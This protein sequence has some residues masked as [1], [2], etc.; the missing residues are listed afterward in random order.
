MTT[1]AGLKTRVAR[2]LRDPSMLTFLD[3]DLGDYV[4]R[5]IVEV[6][7]YAPQQFVEDIALNA[8]QN[9]Y[10]VRGGTGNLLANPSFEGGDATIVQASSPVSVTVGNASNLLSGWLLT[11][12]TLVRFTQSALAKAGIYIGEMTVNAAQAS[13]RLYQD[14]PVNPG[15]TYSFSGWHWKG[16]AGGIANRI[17]VNS[18]DSGSTVIAFNVISHDTTAAVP[19][20]ASGTYTTPA[21]GTVVYLRVELLCN[22]TPSAT[23]V[24]NFDAI[25][26]VESSD[27]NLVADNALQSIELR[28]VEVFDATTSPASSMGVMQPNSAEYVSG[29]ESGWDF[30]NGS[31]TI[32]Y[33]IFT[34]LSTSSN[35]VRVWGWAPYDRLTSD[36]QVTDLSNE[37]EEAV[38]I[39]SRIEGFRALLQDRDLFTQWQTRSHNTDT[40][41]AAVM[42]ALNLAQDDWR[43]LAR[44]LLVLRGS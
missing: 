4:N 43:H 20:Y 27:A 26:L 24:F 30:W 1:F 2:A 3:A 19:V 21:D 10:R 15:T 29:S 35:F 28:R 13:L 11:A 8:G 32:P 23:E 31:L 39:Y 14:V 5:G 33:R 17:R 41:P 16:V 22:G 36:T 18:L 34:G 38:V 6:S 7:K 9:S 44:S 25:S 42:N 37:L 40:S 12:T